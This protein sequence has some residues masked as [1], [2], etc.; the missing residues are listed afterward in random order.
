MSG[1]T[2]LPLLLWTVPA[3]LIVWA[4]RAGVLILIGAAFIGWLTSNKPKDSR[5]GS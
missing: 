2:F 5:Y 1:G 4:V 3:L